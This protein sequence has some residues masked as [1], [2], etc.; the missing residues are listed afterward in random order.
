MIGHPSTCDFLHF[1][2]HNL[3]PNCRITR[4]DILTT[5]HI[6]GP[7]LGSLKGKTVQWKL[8][9]VKVHT[10]SIPATIMEQY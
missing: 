7:D 6:F 8:I 9:L 3:L 1:V 5:E 2:D 10:T 4:W